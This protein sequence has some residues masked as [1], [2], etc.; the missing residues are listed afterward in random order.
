MKSPS[1]IPA[2]TP[3][4]GRPGF[5][6]AGIPARSC[7]N[8]FARIT[9]SLPELMLGAAGI[10][11]PQE[12][13]CPVTDSAV[14]VQSISLYP[15]KSLDPM[16][17]PAAR[18]LSSGALEHDREFAL[19]DEQGNWI[20]GKRDARIHRI[21]A[22]YDLEDVRVTLSVWTIPRRKPFISSRTAGRSKAGLGISSGFPC[23][24]QEKYSGRAFRMIWNRRDQ[25]SWVRRTLREVSAWFEIAGC[26]ADTSSLSTQYRNFERYAILGRPLVRRRGRESGVSNR[27]RHGTWSESLPAVRRAV[28]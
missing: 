8:T 24:L 22:T 2:P 17:V 14:S 21:R 25:R 27:R 1:T 5:C 23:F 11:E 15:I 16:S 26:S 4:P 9:T 19:F 28:A 3:A 6:C 20:N 18:V 13:H 7:S 10:D 12:C